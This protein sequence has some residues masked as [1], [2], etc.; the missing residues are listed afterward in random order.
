VNY[1][2]YIAD[3]AGNEQTCEADTHSLADGV[4]LLYK[5]GEHPTIN[6]MTENVLI[7][8]FNGWS[9][10]WRVPNNQEDK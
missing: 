9:T 10:F 3:S 7:Q 2:Y 1:T 6:F 5:E 4:L 8:G